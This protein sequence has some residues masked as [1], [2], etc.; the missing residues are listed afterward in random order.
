MVG[1]LF[2]IEIKLITGSAKC[3]LEVYLMLIRSKEQLPILQST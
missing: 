3:D 2:G 1:R